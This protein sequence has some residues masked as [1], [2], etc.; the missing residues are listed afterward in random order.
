MHHDIA[1]IHYQPAGIGFPYDAALLFMFN[2]C[3]LDN[4]ISQGI[5]HTVAG[6]STDNEIIC[7]GNQFFNIQQKYIFAF[8]IL[9]GIDNC[10]C[11]FKCIQK[12]PL[13][14]SL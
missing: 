3:L 2:A 1:V 8:L 7:E 11:K 4:P 13:V 5:Q 6:S 12:S 9:Q 10:V 14:L